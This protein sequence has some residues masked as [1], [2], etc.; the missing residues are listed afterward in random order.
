M[1]VL[2]INGGS[3]FPPLSSGKLNTFISEEMQKCLTAKGIE[4]K[5]TKCDTDY[6]AEEEAEKMIWADVI[7]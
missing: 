1:K 2:I 5:I 6:N 4:A 3:N 7:I